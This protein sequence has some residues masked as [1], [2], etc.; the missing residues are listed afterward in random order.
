MSLVRKLDEKKHQ[1]PLK[2][3]P[4]IIASLIYRPLIIVQLV[5]LSHVK[6]Q[7][8]CERNFKRLAY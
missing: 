4:T 8:I 6:K 7:S 3:H 2:E 5:A 1:K